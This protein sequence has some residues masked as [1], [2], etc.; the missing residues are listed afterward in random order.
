MVAPTNPSGNLLREETFT[1]GREDGYS[2][3]Y[4]DSGAVIAEGNYIEGKREGLWKFNNG[5]YVAEGNYADGI[6]YRYGIHQPC[7]ILLVWL[8]V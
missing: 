5:E 3:E 7:S 4:S 2:K 6:L 1:K 8:D